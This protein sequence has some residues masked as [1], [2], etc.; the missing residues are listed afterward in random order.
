MELK[1]FVSQTLVQIFEGVVTAQTELSANGIKINPDIWNNSTAQKEGKLLDPTMSPIE[2]VQFDVAVTASDSA[3]A[4]AKIGVL[5]GIVGGSMEGKGEKSKE[6]VNR[7][8]F[9]V[10]ISFPKAKT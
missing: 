8:K 9:S 3:G 6:L 4:K 7:I 5:S 10:P 1:E 2:E